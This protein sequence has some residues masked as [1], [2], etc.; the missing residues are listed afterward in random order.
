MNQLTAKAKF[1][2]ASSDVSDMP[3][4]CQQFCDMGQ[5]I[6]LQFQLMVACSFS[7][8]KILDVV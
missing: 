8:L 3:W 4:G 1:V 6:C 5:Q 2:T 7:C